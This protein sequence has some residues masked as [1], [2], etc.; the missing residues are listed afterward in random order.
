MVRVWVFRSEFT[1]T[2]FLMHFKTSRN[3]ACSRGFDS[4]EEILGSCVAVGWLARSM[5]FGFKS[6]RCGSVGFVRSSLCFRELHCNQTY[7]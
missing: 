4:F 5:Y 6:A 1:A 3:T 2:G 7:I